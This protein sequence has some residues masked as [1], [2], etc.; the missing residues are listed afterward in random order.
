MSYEE[1][2]MQALVAGVRE[3]R[4]TSLAEAPYV[5]D[6][7]GFEP[8]VNT[9]KYMPIEIGPLQPCALGV[10]HITPQGKAVKMRISPYIAQVGMAIAEK[11]KKS[12]EWTLDFIRRYAKDVTNHEDYHVMSAGMLKGEEITEKGRIAAESVTTRGRYKVKRRL[13]KHD[14]AAFVEAANP[15]A[16]T[17]QLAWRLSELA[18]EVYEGPSGK[19]HRGFL[20]DA[21]REPLYKPIARF[22]W[23]AAKAGFRKIGNYLGG[24]AVPNY[25]PA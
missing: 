5:K 23:Q 12:K 4:R 1:A 17:Y 19:G 18:D 15:K 8:D 24:T 10:T 11:Y 2:A 7:L 9:L 16:S 13:G 20:A 25:V 3:G 21:H 22:G 14:E 6:T